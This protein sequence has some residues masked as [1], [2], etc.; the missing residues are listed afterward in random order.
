VP[1]DTFEDGQEESSVT[2][3]KV[4]NTSDCTL[5]ISR[6]IEINGL[7]KRVSD[8]AST[9]NDIVQF[10][11]RNGGSILSNSFLNVKPTDSSPET[12]KEP[13]CIEHLSPQLQSTLKTKN[14]N[15]NSDY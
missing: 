11:N 2:V 8:I 13:S 10:D 14:L 9:T 15:F 6:S 3:L 12:K 5:S 4:N 1:E 7:L